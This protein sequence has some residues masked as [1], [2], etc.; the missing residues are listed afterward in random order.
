M[1]RENV[2]LG[3]AQDLV[4]VELSSNGDLLAPKK[5]MVFSSC[6]LRLKTDANGSLGVCVGLP[7]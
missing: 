7:A 6:A 5:F 2:D 3:V 1:T 4:N